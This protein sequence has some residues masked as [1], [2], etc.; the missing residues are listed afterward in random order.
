MLP[1]GCHHSIS[2][3][4]ASAV[5]SRNAE[6]KFEKEESL[7]VLNNKAGLKSGEMLIKRAIDVFKAMKGEK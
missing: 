1:V 5:S 3:L 2:P 7:G 4:S 6:G